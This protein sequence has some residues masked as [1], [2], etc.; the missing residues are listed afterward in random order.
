VA[1]GQWLLKNISGNSLLERLS[2]FFSAIFLL[3]PNIF[4]SPT[5][6]RKQIPSGFSEATAH[7]PRTERLL[8]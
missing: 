2:N 8:P 5:E 1:D 6:A 4:F 7:P 3:Y